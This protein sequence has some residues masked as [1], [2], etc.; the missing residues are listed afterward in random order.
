M[1]RKETF[2][3]ITAESRL[4]L[5]VRW[6][7]RAIQERIP[8]ILE[9]AG[10]QAEAES[11]RCGSKLATSSLADGMDATRS[12]LLSVVQRL[13][14]H[15]VL[16]ASKSDDP[17]ETPIVRILG[18]VFSLTGVLKEPLGPSIDADSAWYI[19]LRCLTV[20]SLAGAAHAERIM[21]QAEIS[22]ATGEEDPPVRP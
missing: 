14:E 8:A 2:E 18:A 1:L 20:A 3:A 9:S 4:E 5:A 15:D 21:Q 22:S 12:A 10:Y 6:L 19:W 17:T 16:D 7:N 11:L 13:E